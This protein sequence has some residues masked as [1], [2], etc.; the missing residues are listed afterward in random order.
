MPCRRA[1]RGAL[2]FAAAAALGLPSRALC[3]D[4]DALSQRYRNWTYFP[5]WVIEPLCMN[6]S[7]NSTSQCNTA[8]KRPGSPFAG[9]FSDCFQLVQLPEEAA[10]GVF[11]AFYLQFDG[12]GYETYS[13]ST[14]DMVHFNVSDPTL[15]PGQP[16]VV[17]SPRAGRPPLADAKPVAGDFDFGGAAFIGP[18]VEDYN[19]SA[20]RVLRRAAGGE[21]FFYAYFAQHVAGLEPPPGADGFAVSQDGLDWRRAS[22]RPFLDVDPAHGARAWEQGQIY[23]PFVVP[24]PASSGGALAVFYNA[25]GNNSEGKRAEESGQAYLDGG[26]AALPGIAADG[27]SL[28]RRDAANPTL[29]NN[30]LGTSMASD[31]KVYFDDVQG[32][33]VMVYFCYGG[34]KTGGACICVAF[35]DDQRTW[36]PA[37]TPLYV[38]GGHPAGLDKC[39]AHKAWLT[40]DGK[41][42]RLYLYYTADSCHQG[43]GIALLTST[44]L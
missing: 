10:A 30:A 35:S 38:N 18:L 26:A 15:A 8:Q 39:H 22:T 4:P 37:S 43:R 2:L 13:A 23:A 21:S 9:C 25:V 3:L 29:P 6:P 40:G 12:V 20:T 1:R 41:T 24:A 36:V 5:D 17:F 19:V 7:C 42:G 27:S 31:P 16:G 11:R 14:T 32:V 34:T 28:W 44:P 33:W